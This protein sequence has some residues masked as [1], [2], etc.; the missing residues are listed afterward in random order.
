MATKKTRINI[1]VP[2]D[3]DLAVQKLAKRDNTSLSAKALELVRRA[4][5]IEEDAA[6]LR[7]ATQREA[8]AK[9]SDYAGHEQVWR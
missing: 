7:I 4:I 8:R 3:I 6:L 5:E 9:K 2:A 1:T